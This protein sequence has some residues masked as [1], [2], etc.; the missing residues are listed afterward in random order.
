MTGINSISYTP[1][2]ASDTRQRPP[3][4]LQEL[5]KDEFLKLL[6]AQLQNQDPLNPLKNEEF[7]A[8]LATFSSLE[9]LIAINKGVT[10]ITEFIDPATGTGTEQP[11]PRKQETQ[12]PLTSAFNAALTG[13][14]NNALQ[15]NV[16]GNNLANIN[17]TGYKASKATFAELLSSS[18]DSSGNGNPIQIG[19][20]SFVPSVSPF[21]S[22][23]SIQYTGKSTDA[24]VSG[25]GFFIVS[26]GDGEAYSSAGNF[27][28]TRDGKLVSA[29]GFQVLGYPAVDGVVGQN[30]VLVPI[31]VLKGSAMPP[32]TTSSASIVANLDSRTAVNGRLFRRGPGL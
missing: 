9:Q 15:L 18:S 4:D 25:N 14:N 2:A 17:S 7:V 10:S 20:G 21:F 13:L 19:L 24:A 1:T 6:V 31:T 5:G 22:Q 3:K 32:K 30:S 11:N 27:G 8:Q 29:E 16:I 12:M 28:L 23:G 26:T